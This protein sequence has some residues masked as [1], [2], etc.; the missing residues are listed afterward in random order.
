MSYELVSDANLTYFKNKVDKFIKYKR[1]MVN[2]IGTGHNINYFN[3]K[4]D[5][6][7]ELAFQNNSS[8]EQFKITVKFAR[9][10]FS[11]D[12]LKTNRAYYSYINEQPLNERT[13]KN[14]NTSIVRT[15]VQLIGISV[16]DLI[17]HYFYNNRD[18]GSS[19]DIKAVETSNIDD[20]KPVQIK[21]KV[22]CKYVF[23]EKNL[24]SKYQNDVSD[25]ENNDLKDDDDED[26]DVEEIK[27]IKETFDQ[28]DKD[29]Y[30]LEKEQNEID[31]LCKK[32]LS[33]DTTNASINDILGVYF[34]GGSIYLWDL[35]REKGFINKSGNSFN[36]FCNK[37]VYLDEYAIPFPYMHP[38]IIKRIYK[39]DKK[40][41]RRVKKK[42]SNG[43]IKND[44]EIKEEERLLDLIFNE[45]L[46]NV[47]NNLTN[48]TSS[49]KIF[50]YFMYNEDPE[51]VNT[52][53]YNFKEPQLVTNIL[54]YFYAQTSDNKF[55]N[56]YQIIM[57]DL[58][59]NEREQ[60][61]TKYKDTLF[62]KVSNVP[63]R[64]PMFAFR[65]I[66]VKQWSNGDIGLIDDHARDYFN[67]KINQKFKYKSRIQEKEP[68]W[69]S[70]YH[71]NCNNKLNMRKYG[72]TYNQKQIALSNN[73]KDAY[74]LIEYEKELELE[75]LE[76]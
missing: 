43:Q 22:K 56:R 71:Y 46:S 42:K 63:D 55:I 61:D 4:D 9:L 49:T 76:E 11:L 40:K 33:I 21:K 48:K 7:T 44:Y 70:R 19:A 64:Y 45:Q 29:Q 6:S 14:K 2:C 10:S 23:S 12:L 73:I 32:A 30:E 27:E 47:F 18:F 16:G 72:M 20:E 68:D 36:E 51:I 41:L 31:N 24:D 13:E 25:T 8:G 52:T 50:K 28:A 17:K 57:K 53:I 65:N 60:L 54:K 62:D 74:D 37:I 69:D 67:S 39:K 1:T 66:Y 35:L 3:I 15:D 26:V 59:A 58:N 34:P 38:N 5:G 75:E